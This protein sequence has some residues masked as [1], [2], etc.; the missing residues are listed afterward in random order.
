MGRTGPAV[1]LL[2]L[3][4]AVLALALL[5]GG[6]E[7]AGEPGWS[8]RIREAACVESERVR[9]GDIA[10]PVGP[11]RSEVWQ[12]LAARPLW[13]SPEYSGRQQA[14]PREQIAKMLA[15]YVPEVADSCVLP[16]RLVVQKGGRVFER[17][18]L[19]RLVVDF[20][21]P[22]AASLG[23]EPEIKDIR[24]PSFLFLDDAFD[25]VEVALNNDLKPGRVNM[26]IRAV[27]K[28]GRITRRVATSAFVNLWKAVPCAAKPI[29]R[30]ESVTPDKVMFMRKNLAY[31]G[32]VWDGKSGPYRMNRSVGTG[33]PLEMEFLDG[34]PMVSKGDTVNLVYRGPRI[35]LAVKAEAL[36]DG[37]QGQ[38]VEVRNL[39]SKKTVL[40]TVVDRNT[41]SV[42]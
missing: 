36:A 37:D 40:A 19:E 11:V 32:E 38:T 9:L 29:N 10:E 35:T 7:A 30:L 27:A 24:L 16:G 8:L 5:P 2:L 6:A 3:A 42:R 14:L 15:Y 25:Q 26:L 39:Q 31:L 34:E 28:D 18:A 13:M 22:K 21:T 33:Q 12:E 23:G 1:V 41:V 20:L 4:A 17:R